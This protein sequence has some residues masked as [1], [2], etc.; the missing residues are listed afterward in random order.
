MKKPTKNPRY[1]VGYNSYAAWIYDKRLAYK[2]QRD[3]G[4]VMRFGVLGD[5]YSC[6]HTIGEA[7][8]LARKVC[9][10]LNKETP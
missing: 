5:G 6:M 9:R 1:T 3:R 7:K 4:Y 10:F 8:R 2:G